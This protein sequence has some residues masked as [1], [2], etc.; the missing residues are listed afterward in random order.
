MEPVEHALQLS[1][2]KCRVLKRKLDASD[3]WAR[4]H[5]AVQHRLRMGLIRLQAEQQYEN[6]VRHV[7]H[8]LEDLL[9][10]QYEVTFKRNW[11]QI[12]TGRKAIRINERGDVYT[13]TGKAKRFNI[14]TV[15]YDDL[16]VKLRQLA[17]RSRPF[18]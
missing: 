10:W 13:K 17:L 12:V 5:C 2:N 7:K 15:S 3:E 16:R 8:I 14:F 1:M 6:L 4:E 9:G 18:E 11:A